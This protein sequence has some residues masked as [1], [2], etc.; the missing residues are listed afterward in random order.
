MSDCYILQDIL[1]YFFECCNTCHEYD[2]LNE[3]Y[4]PFFE[5]YYLEC[6]CGA[7][8]VIEELTDLEWFI[9]AYIKKW[10]EITD[11]FEIKLKEACS[12]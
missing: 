4:E 6:C 2:R 5:E 10:K 7:E 1:G 11:L 12:E 9:I 8:G 3:Y